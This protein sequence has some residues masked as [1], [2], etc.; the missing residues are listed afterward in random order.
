MTSRPHF[1]MTLLRQLDS[2]VNVVLTCFQIEKNQVLTDENKKLK[3]KCSNLEEL[4][5]EE[6]MNIADMLELIRT[7]QLAAKNGCWLN[8]DDGCSKH[9]PSGSLPP[10]IAAG[11]S[12]MRW[13]MSPSAARRESPAASAGGGLQADVRARVGGGVAGV[14]RASGDACV[15]PLA[16]S[17]PDR[18]SAGVVPHLRP[19]LRSSSARSLNIF[20]MVSSSMCRAARNR[21]WCRRCARRSCVWFSPVPCFAAVASAFAGRG[22][23]PSGGGLCSFGRRLPLRI[24]GRAPCASLGRSAYG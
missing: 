6:E 22:E 8:D 13:G 20:S 19:P 2:E 15:G 24:G 23:P 4:L 18:L 1:N 11:R 5:S 12:F 17:G 10:L 3:E 21:S 14:G 9:D 16:R 7:M